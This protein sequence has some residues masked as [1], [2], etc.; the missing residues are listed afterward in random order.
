LDYVS[1]VVDVN[2]NGD[3]SIGRFLLDSLFSLFFFFFFFFV[4]VKTKNLI[5][6]LLKE[7]YIYCTKIPKK[8]K[9]TPKIVVQS[10]AMTEH[11][12]KNF[13]LQLII[14][15]IFFPYSHTFEA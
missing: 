6:K 12:K 5:N 4:K 15:Y 1:F 8:Q 9:Q 14:G 2:I 13:F 7:S 3:V 10:H 11:K